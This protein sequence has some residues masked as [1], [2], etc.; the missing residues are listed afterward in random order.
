MRDKVALNL[1]V[2]MTKRTNKKLA[3]DNPFF[4]IS[5]EEEGGLAGECR[6]CQARAVLTHHTWHTLNFFLLA[7]FKNLSLPCSCTSN[8]QTL[9]QAK[10]LFANYTVMEAHY[11]GQHSQEIRVHAFPLYYEINYR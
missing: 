8:Y 9:C 2:V 6:V 3:Q 4:S 5:V 7:Y 11:R 10:F 1:P